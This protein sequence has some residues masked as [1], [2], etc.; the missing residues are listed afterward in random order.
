MGQRSFLLV[1]VVTEADLGV[2]CRFQSDQLLTSFY[3]FPIA[4]A[5]RG[6][7]IISHVP[8][9]LPAAQN[10]LQF[11]LQTHGFSKDSHTDFGKTGAHLV[12][13]PYVV[14]RST[15]R[16]RQLMYCDV[17]SVVPHPEL[18]IFQE[19]HKHRL[20]NKSFPC[21]QGGVVRKELMGGFP[22]QHM[23]IFI[24]G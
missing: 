7:S 17:N 24:Q 4:L 3:W 22:D 20:I 19:F 11:S 9:W 14:S 18:F 10:R 12:G 1:K 21:W 23:L 8:N 13:L 6:L 15:C 16:S 2:I 5:I